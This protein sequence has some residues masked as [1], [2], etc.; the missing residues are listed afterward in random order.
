MCIL[1]ICLTGL[2]S[3]ANND[4]TTIIYKTVV[5]PSGLKMRIAP[6]LGSEVLTVIPYGTKLHFLEQ[7]DQELIVE[8]MS[9][10]WNRVSYGT[11][12]GYVFGGFI[13]GFDIPSEEHEL[14]QG[15]LDLTYPLI[16]WMEH[17]YKSVDSSDTINSGTN[18]TI[19]QYLESNQSLTR[20]NT[21]YGFN[22][23]AK[24]T[25]TT[26]AEVYNLLRAMLLTEEEKKTY[27]DKSVFIKDIHA[28]LSTIKIIVDSPI[29][30]DQ[31]QD[32]MIVVTVKSYHRGC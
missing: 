4:P 23:T 17:Q 1:I 14:T 7:T 30:I 21:L 15:E 3:K 32:G 24:I 5:A 18:E 31:E 12:E 22:V 19:I 16:S 10:Y 26:I 8:W 27:T 6:D 11:M 2:S 29:L 9:G 28:E 13:S 25:D 20:T